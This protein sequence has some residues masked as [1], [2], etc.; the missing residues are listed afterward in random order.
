MSTKIEHRMKIAFDILDPVEQ[1]R[2]DL[3]VQEID[4]A[5][6]RRAIAVQPPRITIKQQNR[7]SL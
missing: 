6:V 4:A 2:S 7:N 1:A 3:R 5:G